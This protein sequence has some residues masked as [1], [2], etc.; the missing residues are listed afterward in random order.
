[1]GSVWPSYLMHE[2]HG[3]LHGDILACLILGLWG[4]DEVNSDGLELQTGVWV[5]DEIHGMGH[6]MF[7]STSME[8]TLDW[9]VSIIT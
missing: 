9:K 8:M 7:N 3:R 4:E 5:L 6:G 2:L 1:M